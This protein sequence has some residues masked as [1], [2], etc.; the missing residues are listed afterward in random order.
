ME[1]LLKEFRDDIAQFREMTEKFYANEVSVKEY[2]GFSGGFGSYAQKGGTASMLRLRLPG[3]RI[4]KEKL[5]FIVDSIQEYGIEKV[6]VTTCQTVQFHNL[7]METV[8]EIMESLRCGYYHEGRRRR[9]PEEC[10][11]VPVIRRGTGGV[12]RRDALCAG[13]VGLFAGNH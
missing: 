3:G 2:K 1:Q 6:H 5:K 8:C 11:G 9:L 13:S 7:S 12:F 10:D 4:D